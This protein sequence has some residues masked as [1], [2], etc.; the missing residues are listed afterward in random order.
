MSIFKL[1]H[2]VE[3]EITS[4][5]HIFFD[6]CVPA[7]V[8]QDMS[9]QLI[10]VKNLKI[11]YL[12]TTGPLKNVILLNCSIKVIF[13]ENLQNRRFRGSGPPS[14]D[15]PQNRKID[16]I[17]QNNRNFMSNHKTVKTAVNMAFQVDLPILGLKMR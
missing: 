1:I 7:H 8:S 2:G 6:K 5:A 3:A 13:S 10:L 11:M 15:T 17:G 9:A 16:K 12:K 14:L 4:P